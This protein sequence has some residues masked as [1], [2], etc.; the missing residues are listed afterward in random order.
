MIYRKLIEPQYLQ[1]RGNDDTS[2][3]D[4]W[5]LDDNSF[6]ANESSMKSDDESNKYY[7]SIL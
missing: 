7:F 1:I 2:S 6:E 5:D 3:G 4:E